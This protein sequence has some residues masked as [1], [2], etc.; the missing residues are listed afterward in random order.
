MRLPAR[1]NVAVSLL[2]MA[3]AIAC[4]DSTG[5]KEQTSAQ[6]A[7]HFDS[8]AIDA[9]ARG[10]DYGVRGMMATLI[11][12]PAA[13]GAVPAKVSVTTA[14]GVESWKAYELLE[15][16]PPGSEADSSFAL[17]MFRDADAHTA[18]LVFFDS[19]GTGEGG[20]V[21]TGD[22]IF[23]SPTDAGAMTSLSSVGSACATPAASLVNPQ[24]G[25]L[26]I[27]TCSLAGFRTSLQLTLPT[28]DGMDPALTNVSFTNATV[29]GVRAVGQAAGASIQR[30]HDMLR[31]AK[32]NR[33]F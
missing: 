20:G 33:H 16:S 26:A 10:Q 23:V 5:P 7:A 28:T 22:T 11:E 18:L 15:V 19:T 13:L 3:F 17:L 9:A 24:L 4:S 8:I 1:V 25:M 6:V 2:A 14:S 30:I 21:I 29:N 31:A 12:L 27:G 32:A